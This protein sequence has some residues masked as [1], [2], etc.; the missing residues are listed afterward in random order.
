MCGN[1]VMTG[2]VLIR[3]AMAGNPCKILMAHVLVRI[4][5][6]VGE[7]GVAVLLIAVPLAVILPSQILG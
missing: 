3:P 5:C 2:T 1:G 7:R 4:V 6:Y